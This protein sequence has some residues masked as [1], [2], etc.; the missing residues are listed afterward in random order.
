MD[1]V[2]TNSLKRKHRLGFTKAGRGN[3]KTKRQQFFFPLFYFSVVYFLKPPYPIYVE[4]G[5]VLVGR[6][7]EKKV[8]P[9][10][11][12]TYLRNRRAQVHLHPCSQT[13]S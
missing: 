6:L 9:P 1:V 12:A 10:Y 8:V 11:G 5:I 2:L 3:T 7:S 13:M 4:V